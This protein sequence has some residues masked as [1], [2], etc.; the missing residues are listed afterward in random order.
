MSGLE[1]ALVGLFGLAVLAG[2]I[3]AFLV[4]R[5]EFRRRV[6]LAKVRAFNRRR[7]VPPRAKYEQDDMRY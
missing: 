3:A 5:G 4:I 6:G 2:V 7:P 1:L